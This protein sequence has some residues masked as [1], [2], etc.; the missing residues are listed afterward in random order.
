VLNLCKYFYKYL[1]FT[2]FYPHGMY[3]VNIFEEFYPNRLST[4]WMECMF[5]VHLNYPNS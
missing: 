1:M 3:T 4:L 2:Y 5:V